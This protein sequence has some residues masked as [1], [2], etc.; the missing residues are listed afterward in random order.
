V[1]IADSLVWNEGVV[2]LEIDVFQRRF[3]DPTQSKPSGQ[4][5]FGVLSLAKTVSNAKGKHIIEP[6]LRPQMEGWESSNDWIVDI[7]S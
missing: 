6:V 5:I 3:S 4:S 1:S 7:G 2:K